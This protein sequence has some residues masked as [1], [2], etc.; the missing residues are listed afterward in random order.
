[1]N[2]KIIGIGGGASNAVNELVKSN[3]QNAIVINTDK[4]GLDKS[5]TS[6]KL[7]I[8]TGEGTNGNA[9]LGTKAAVEAKDKIKQVLSGSDLNIFVATLG[10]GTGSG[11]LPIAVDISKS[12]NAFTVCIVT[13][14]FSFESPMRKQVAER[15][16]ESIKSKADVYFIVDYQKIES[17]P[18]VTSLPSQT[19]MDK[20]IK[21]MDM[22]I[23]N[24]VKSVIEI[25]LKK[26]VKEIA[27]AKEQMGNSV[28]LDARKYL[29]EIGD[30][31]HLTT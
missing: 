3:V 29:Q 1:M 23:A 21:A 15:T 25:A 16:I 30:G 18:A 10:G 26:S 7:L 20:F 9:E 2:I 17:D 8:G 4:L 24:A 19:P 27:A 31:G 11:V 22:V 13:K 6:A 5:K 28:I 14:P 12:L